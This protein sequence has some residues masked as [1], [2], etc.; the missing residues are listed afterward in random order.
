MLKEKHS[1]ASI[2]VANLEKLHRVEEIVS[3]TNN[4]CFIYGTEILIQLEGIHATYQGTILLRMQYHS[5]LFSLY[6]HF[7]FDYG[8]S[9]WVHIK[10]AARSL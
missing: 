2:K 7:S 6:L 4:R 3:S 8:R 10:L 9:I 5:A 1:V